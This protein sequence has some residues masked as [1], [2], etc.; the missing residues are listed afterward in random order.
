MT[1]FEPWKQPWCSLLP[2]ERRCTRTGTRP[3]WEH[4]APN[5]GI[6]A[7]RIGQRRIWEPDNTAIIHNVLKAYPN[8]TLLDVGARSGWFSMLGLALGHRTLAVEASPITICFTQQ[9]ALR[10]RLSNLITVNRPVADAA[11]IPVRLAGI[12]VKSEESTNEKTRDLY[13]QPGSGVGTVLHTMKLDALIPLLTVG[14]QLVIQMDIESYECFA[15]RGASKLLNHTMVVAIVMEW[16]GPP[17]KCDFAPVEAQMLSLGLKPHVLVPFGRGKLN[18]LKGNQATFHVTRAATIVWL[19]Q[20]W[21]SAY[22]H[23]MAQLNSQSD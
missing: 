5:P 11:G 15:L 1:A 18:A 14:E 19:R 12:K 23:E 13:S 17:A 9:N 7:D 4:C 3:S 10:N 2:K 20:D 16:G 8:S 22:E 6:E 21:K